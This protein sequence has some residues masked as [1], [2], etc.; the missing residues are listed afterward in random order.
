[1]LPDTGQLQS[2]ILPLEQEGLVTRT[3]RRLDPDRQLAV[4]NAILDE[5][6]ERGPTNVN[7]KQV[8]QRAG[9][10]VGSL[11]QYFADRDQMLAFAVELCVRYI[12]DLFRQYGP[13][14]AALPLRQGLREYLVGGIEWGRDQA[15]LLQLFARA[16]YQGDPALNKRLVKPIADT[17]RRMVGDMLEQAVRRGEIRLGV[18]IDIATR[19]VHCLTIA[20]G[21][22]QLLPYLNTYFQITDP[23]TPPEQLVEV[24]LDF[25]LNGIGTEAA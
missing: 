17:L 14:L 19:L 3:F 20:V 1:M 7:I 2:Y 18:N 25:I 4:I 13:Y 5:A 10:A 6:A 16:A 15:G 21:D 24:M 9:V 8:A 22:S 11:Y 23:L 12:N